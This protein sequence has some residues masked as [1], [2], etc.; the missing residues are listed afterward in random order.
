MRIPD[1]WYAICLKEEIPDKGTLAVRRFGTDL[2]IWRTT[3]GEPVVM[4]DRCPHRGA[5]LSLGTTSD[6]I[7]CPYHG[8]KFSPCGSCEVVPETGRAAPN[9]TVAVY[10]SRIEHGIFWVFSGDSKQSDQLLPPWFDDITADFSMS[11]FKQSWNTHITRCIEN[12]LDYAHL[13]FVHQTTIGGNFDPK[14][15]VHFDLQ[16]ETI[17]FKFDTAGPNVI[18]FRMPNIWINRIA[19]KFKLMLIFAPVDD[20]NTELY[21]LS[22]QQF[23]TVP[24][25]RAVVGGLLNLT[26]RVILKQDRAVVLSQ[27]PKDSTHSDEKLFPSDRAI[28]HFRSVW[29]R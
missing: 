13:A 23:C 21:L 15:S 16:Q 6:T 9:L 1:G 11:W 3:S 26:S 25:L 7:T 18:E 10:P 28:S 4:Q 8:F 22:F 12:Q 17:G 27:S 19:P 5:K 24:L 2:V 14:R 29:I 20:E